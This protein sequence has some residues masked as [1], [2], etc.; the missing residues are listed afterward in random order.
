MGQGLALAMHGLGSGLTALRVSVRSWSG[1]LFY[2]VLPSDRCTL[3]GVSL[4]VLSMALLACYIPARRVAKLDP[5]VVL[6][7]E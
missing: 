7:S 5:M 6:R 1:L 3:V 4:L 2:G